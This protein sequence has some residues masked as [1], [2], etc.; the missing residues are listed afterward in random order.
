MFWNQYYIDW[1]VGLCNWFYGLGFQLD[2]TCNTLFKCNK[3][4][5]KHQ[6]I[7]KIITFN[8]N[9]NLIAGIV[10]LT[11]VLSNAAW[12]QKSDSLGHIRVLEI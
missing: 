6:I 10:V 3:C 9:Y 5:I 8:N 11:V 2:V 7:N 4:V 1:S 12:P